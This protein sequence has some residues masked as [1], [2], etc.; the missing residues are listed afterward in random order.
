MDIMNR[1]FG[2][3]RRKKQGEYPSHRFVIGR[4]SEGMSQKVLFDARTGK[5]INHT[6][7]VVFGRSDIDQLLA[8]TPQ[9]VKA[10]MENIP[11]HRIH[12]KR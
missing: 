6:G 1:I 10:V 11:H 2:L 7:M 12:I 8:S 9:E 5:R 4:T 3:F